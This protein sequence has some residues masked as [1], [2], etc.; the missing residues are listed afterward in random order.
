MLN[1]KSVTLIFT[2]CLTATA[3]LHAA[4]PPEI[5]DVA[6]EWAN[7]TGTDDQQH[8]WKDVAKDNDVIVVC[9]TCNTCPYAVDYEDRL[10]AL[11]DKFNRSGT[12]A[13]LIAINSN[14]IPADKLEAMKERAAQKHF[15]FP[16]V[17]DAT[18]EVAR[19]YGAIYTP[20]FFVLNRE[21][22]LV[23]RGA[24]DDSTNADRVTV[25]Y[26][27]LAVAAALEGKMPQTTKVGA[28]GCTIRFARK[29]R[30]SQD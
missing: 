15:N 19:A 14:G 7:L 21:R 17:S 2:T 12:K 28:R 29:R 23:Y 13:Q 22:K 20:E 27:E 11:Q 6:P 1:L 8:S 25:R 5:G 18:Q 26:V 16:Y 3:I 30:G 4:E 10:I 24:M 9:F